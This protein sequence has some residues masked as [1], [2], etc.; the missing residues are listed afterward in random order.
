MAEPF[1]WARVLKH[2]FVHVINL[3]QTGFNL[4]HWYAEALAVLNE[5]Y[6]RSPE[7]NE[8]L[9]ARVSG[10]DIF[11]LD[12][13]NLGFIRPQSSDDWTMAY[14]QAELYAEYMLRQ[15]GEDSLA[16]MLTAFADN[17]TTREAV[18]RSFGVSQEEFEKGYVS[19]LDQ[20]VGKLSA[21]S[22]SGASGRKYPYWTFRMPTWE[23][24]PC[25]IHLP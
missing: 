14:C 12:T 3:Q 4:P 25:A 6:P 19:Y 9:L 23:Q 8:L 5:G 24:N 22:K 13:I 18:E 15:F 10:G 7:W 17:L 21:R 2:E 20:V 1:N 11:N 16:K